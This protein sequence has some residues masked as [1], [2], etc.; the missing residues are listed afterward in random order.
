[1]YRFNRLIGV[2]VLIGAS[3][4]SSCT[5]AYADSCESMVPYG[6]PMVL[7]ENSTRLCRTSYMVIHDNVR[8]IPILTAHRFTKMS[9]SKDVGRH[10][11]FLPDPD[12]AKGSRSELSDYRSGRKIYDRGHLVPFEDINYTRQSATESFYLSNMAPQFSKMN[13]GLWKTIETK[14]RKYGEK[15]VAKGQDV[16]VFTGTI[17][18]D[19]DPTIGKNQVVVPDYFYKVVMNKSTDEIVGL[20]VRNDGSKS[21]GWKNYIVPVMVIS[22]LSG[23]EFTPGMT[24]DEVNKLKMLRL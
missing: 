14:V 16:Y 4:L 12:L 22:Q 11:V 20:L 10:N 23:I 13:R 8:K 3:L 5:P 19:G 1:M 2:V 17:V 21:T 24:E 9:F 7:V 6:E 18:D 15:S